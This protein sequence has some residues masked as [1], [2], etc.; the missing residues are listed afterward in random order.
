MQVLVSNGGLLDIFVKVLAQKG[1]KK[2]A[3]K[4][5]DDWFCP[6]HF[7]D[8]IV[9]VFVFCSVDEPHVEVGPLL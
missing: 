4:M 8:V 1:E 2:I 9:S 3:P 6:V 7:T 5:T